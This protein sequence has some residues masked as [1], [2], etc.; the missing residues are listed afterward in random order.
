M[1][2]QPPYTLTTPILNE[3][4]AISEQI[5]RITA[6]TQQQDLRLRRVSPQVSLQVSPQ[7]ER[8]A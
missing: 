1:P 7:V 8:K 4:A 2:Y 5:G 3:V 6:Q